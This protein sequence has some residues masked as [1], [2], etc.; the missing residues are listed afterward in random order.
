MGWATKYCSL[1]FWDSPNL[2][3][4]G[5]ARCLLRSTRGF[6]GSRGDVGRTRFTCC[7]VSTADVSPKTGHVFS[8]QKGMVDVDHIYL[9]I[10]DDWSYWYSRQGWLV[11]WLDWLFSDN[12]TCCFCS[13]HKSAK[14]SPWAK[15]VFLC[16]LVTDRHRF[17]TGTSTGRLIPSLLIL[18]VTLPWYGPYVNSSRKKLWFLRGVDVDLPTVNPRICVAGIW[19]DG[20]GESQKHS[21]IYRWFFPMFRCSDVPMKTSWNPNLLLLV[22]GLKQMIF[23]HFSG[24]VWLVNWSVG[25]PEVCIPFKGMPDPQWP[26]VCWWRPSFFKVNHPNPWA[27]MGHGSFSIRFFSHQEKEW[28]YIRNQTSMYSVHSK[29]NHH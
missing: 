11:G 21:P 6:I 29:Y 14:F 15:A 12:F 27:M 5:G 13:P 9:M 8:P 3:F 10:F 7:M 22:F 26:A 4:F 16:F 28:L 17:F 1:P 20:N 23:Q 2:R 24:Q 25:A 19:Q 18:L